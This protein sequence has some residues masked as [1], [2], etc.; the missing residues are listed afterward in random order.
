MVTSW[1]WSWGFG[2]IMREG[3]PMRGV[4]VGVAYGEVDID[5]V[6]DYLLTRLSTGDITYLIDGSE[7]TKVVH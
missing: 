3:L 7:V 1:A 6:H 2:Y 5:H 4:A